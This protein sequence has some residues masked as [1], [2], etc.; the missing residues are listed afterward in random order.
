[1]LLLQLAVSVRSWRSR[2]LSK[3][4]HLNLPGT[5]LTE[6]CTPSMC[7]SLHTD[8]YFNGLERTAIDQSVIDQS[9]CK[10]LAVSPSS[11]AADSARSNPPSKDR[12][13]DGQMFSEVHVTCTA[14]ATFCCHKPHTSCDCFDHTWQGQHCP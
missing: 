6:L 4:L 1:M 11:G 13:G 2:H 10:H 12:G 9:V 14:Q 7:S 3:H 5:C 8:C